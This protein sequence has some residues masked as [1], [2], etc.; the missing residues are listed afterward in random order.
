[1]LQSSPTSVREAALTSPTLPST[2]SRTTGTL[3]SS[4]HNH[5]N[6]TTRFSFR[7]STPRVDPIMQCTTWN[8][9]SG[10]MGSGTRRFLLVGFLVTR[11]LRYA[12]VPL[13]RF[14]CFVC[15]RSWQCVAM[16]ELC[17]HQ[18]TV[19]NALNVKLFIHA[20]NLEEIEWRNMM[21]VVSESKCLR[22]WWWCFVIN[23]LYTK[24]HMSNLCM[25]IQYIQNIQ[26]KS[27][28]QFPDDS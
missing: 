19:K 4:S 14:H 16:Y 11:L 24:W 22:G 9:T 7:S 10:R 18:G 12:K 28:I 21:N 23:Q 8:S 6:K 27:I 15:A 13:R 2:R 25:Y 1:M 3:S 26:F 20:D 5:W 17:R